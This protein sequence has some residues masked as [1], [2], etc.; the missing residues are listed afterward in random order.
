MKEANEEKKR[1]LKGTMPP[2]HPLYV[3]IT[4]STIKI[5]MHDIEGLKKLNFYFNKLPIFDKQFI[6]LS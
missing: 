2:I 1:L 5:F 6:H 3:K 4:F